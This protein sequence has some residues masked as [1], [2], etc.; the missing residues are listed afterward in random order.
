MTESEPRRPRLRPD[1]LVDTDSYLTEDGRDEI[2]LGTKFDREGVEYE[3]GILPPYVDI[4]GVQVHPD[5][6]DD[7]L[8]RLE[9][10]QKKSNH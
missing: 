3:D 9:E 1:G 2:P 10:A 8:A 4:D 6:L 7:Y 5:R